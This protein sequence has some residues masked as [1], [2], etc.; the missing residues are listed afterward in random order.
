VPA[1]SARA[2][3]AGEAEADGDAAVDAFAFVLTAGVGLADSFVHPA[4]TSKSMR[5]RL[6]TVV[7]RKRFIIATPLKLI[8]RGPG[9]SAR[10][11]LWTILHA[12]TIRV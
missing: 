10:T 7:F 6:T 1:V 5:E 2:D 9:R 11:S 8:L 12:E 3:V 4:A